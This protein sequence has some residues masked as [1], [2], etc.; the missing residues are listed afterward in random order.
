MRIVGGS[1]RGREIS[2][3]AGEA[4]RPTAD[5]VRQSLFDRLGQ[6]CDG[7]AVLDLYSGTGA[8]ALEAL[9][10]GAARAVLVEQARAAAKV[11]A[12]NAAKLGLAITLVQDDAARAL[13]QLAAKGERFEL[14]FSDPPYALRAAQRTLDEIARLGLLAPGGRLVLEHGKE[15]PPPLAPEG[16]LLDSRSYGEAHVTVLT[17]PA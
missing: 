12:A 13:G 10:R 14:I 7:L 11:I 6:R 8:L 3:V 1:K 9:S 5:R 2:A 17:R 16:W 15:E 4:T